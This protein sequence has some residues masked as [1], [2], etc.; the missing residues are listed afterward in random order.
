MKQTRAREPSQKPR[1]GL[2]DPDQDSLAIEEIGKLAALSKIEYER[3]RASAA[4]KLK[5]RVSALDQWV[6]TER[7]RLAA[8]AE[9]EQAQAE[10]GKQYP[11]QVDGQKLF[12]EIVRTVKTHTV[13]PDY[14][15][16]LL[17]LWVFFTHAFLVMHVSPIL[18]LISVVKRCGKTTA[19]AL[20]QLLVYRPL[21]TANITAAALFRSVEMFRPTLLI[22]EGDTFLRKSDELNGIINSGHT[23]PTAYV[24][25]MEDNIPKEFS[26]WCAKAFA[27]IG[28]L[29]ETMQD[30]SLAIRMRRKRA[31]ETIRP[32]R[33]TDPKEFSV[34]KAKIARWTHDNLQA[35]AECR[36]TLPDLNNDRAKDNWEPLLMIA[37]T[38]GPECAEK[39]RQAAADL[40][41]S[42]DSPRSVA[43]EFLADAAEIFESTGM[44]KIRTITLI[45]HLCENKEKPWATFNRGRAIS[46]RQIAQ[47]LAEFG[48]KSKRLRNGD[49]VAWGYELAEFEDAFARYV[50]RVEA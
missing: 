46:A 40:A 48:I 16:V 13:L 14:G 26:T 4:Q 1:V 49:E 22:D 39:A 9:A 19:L 44:T 50:T 27:S 15:I 21:T 41:Q 31:S 32:L 24:I 28:V 25:R 23:K 43:E 6:Q 11:R 45:R 5:V 36:P 34:L 33:D 12:A 35:I 42:W 20:L 8:E 2:G 37:E 18:A 30:R 29:P 38:I 3:K 17:V 7:D 10:E 47:I